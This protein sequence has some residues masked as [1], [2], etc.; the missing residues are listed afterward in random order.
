MITYSDMFLG[1]LAMDSYQRSTDRAFV[2]PTNWIGAAH[3]TH[4]DDEDG[5][6]ASSYSWGDK[7]VISYVGTNNLNLNPFDPQSDVYGGW[8]VGAGY[9]GAGSQAPFAT[10]F[11]T[12]ATGGRSVYDTS[13]DDIVLTGHSLG[14]GLAGFV[15]GLTHNEAVVFD[16]MPFAL[17][18]RAQYVAEAMRQI[19]ES[20]TASAA[21]NIFD[22][23]P[24]ARLAALALLT[25]A[26]LAANIA[27]ALSHITLEPPIW[28]SDVTAYHVAG[29]VLGGV[30]LGASM[31][32]LS[33]AAAAIV[34]VVTLAAGLASGENI[35]N[36]DALIPNTTVSTF[37][38]TGGDGLERH[39]QALQVI[40]MHAALEEGVD[41]R[42]A[43][44]S[45]LLD[46]FFDADVAHALGLY[47]VGSANKTKAADIMLRQIAYTVLQDANATNAPFGDAGVRA[48]FNDAT[49][50]AMAGGSGSA[51][52]ALSQIA[53]Q[54]G[55]MLAQEKM[56]LSS[57]PSSV[58]GVM[59]LTSDPGY[60]SV[61]LTDGRWLGHS[62]TIAG[63]DTLVDEVLGSSTLDENAGR[64]AMELLWG[65]S[66]SD[67]IDRVK[68]ATSDDGGAIS[69]DADASP[70]NLT[71][72]M[73]GDG[74]DQVT[75]SSGDD[76]VYGG[77]GADSL[78]G[79]QGNDLLAGGEGSDTFIV[80]LGNDA[81]LGGF[82]DTDV[83][84]YGS[85]PAGIVVDGTFEGRSLRIHDG[86]GG[87]DLLS[88][89]ELIKGTSFKDHF[90]ITQAAL[91][92]LPA[93]TTIDA[94]GP[95]WTSDD[96]DEIS[97]VGFD[98]GITLGARGISTGNLAAG[99]IGDFSGSAFGSLT[100][101]NFEKIFLTEHGDVLDTRLRSE[102]FMGD[103]DDILKSAG[104]NSIIHPGEGADE[105]HVGLGQA[106]FGLG[107][108]DR[109]FVAGREFFGGIR[110]AASNLVWGSGL[111]GS[112]KFVF[113]EAADL[114]LTLENPFFDDPNNRIYL[115]G[116]GNSAQIN[117]DGL[118]VG[119]GGLTIGESLITAVGLL[120]PRHTAEGYW[121]TWKLFGYL[122]KI[123]TG[124][125]VVFGGIDPL[126]L[127]LDGDGFE[128]TALG[129]LSP[130]FDVDADL[131][132]ERTGWIGR[133]DGMLARDLDGDGKINDSR[134]LFGGRSSGLAALALLD[135]N[136]DG[137]VNAVDSG[138]ADFNGDGVVNGSDS[139]GSLK[140]WRDLNENGRA[141]DGELQSL[142]THN[143]TSISVT[144]TAANQTIEGNLLTATATFTR[145][146]GT[147]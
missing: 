146:D 68:I 142:S 75:G 124:G 113:N 17:A 78:E 8:S 57:E 16:H 41:W 125:A 40:L 109:L 14:G 66:A 67:K 138:L 85:A 24:T 117:G 2:V 74:A 104:F 105:I 7:T 45:E 137:V 103:G 51:R 120:D 139:F 64:S 1:L 53:T 115:E 44:V 129:G 29:E 77:G 84:D 42:S 71:L 80:G 98:H 50:I 134:E 58:D 22:S 86:Q 121:N 112:V 26:Y 56:L 136:H 127:D 79:G 108:D 114:V 49:D 25:P 88:D 34:N 118:Q 128:L 32:G 65:S 12:T 132:G 122:A 76:M 62:D 10:Q 97:F 19:A 82:G 36:L 43:G 15:A 116:W 144:G 31:A 60:L 133:D 27:S 69:L 99:F 90:T 94:G 106:I 39:S 23:T 63:R 30:R 70:A 5:F 52:K 87:V 93:F 100:L 13:A 96:G 140:I 61:N 20:A 89:I 145:G 123:A 147:T 48:I 101:K 130:I 92:G 37:D 107:V 38:W 110:N 72:L 4:S 83:V 111:G 28:G 6:S 35:S 102:F 81:F 126:V 135:G 54:F 143:I 11:Y 9:T 21:L 95:G 141:D 73:L 59:S 131:Y 33:P 3:L 47:D 91:E 18:A 46:S 119:P 55:G